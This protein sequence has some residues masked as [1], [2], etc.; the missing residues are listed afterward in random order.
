MHPALIFNTFVKF[1]SKQTSLFFQLM[2]TAGLGSIIMNS[3][4]AQTA[5]RCDDPVFGAAGI[6]IDQRAATAV[7]ARE[8]GVKKATETALLQVLSRVLLSDADRQRFA[9]THQS[10]AFLDFVHII[11]ENNLDKRYIASLDFCFDAHRMRAAL[12]ADGLQWAE[13]ESPPILLLPVWEDPDGASAW[14]KNNHWIAGWRAEVTS[15]SGLVNLQ[16]L[17][18]TLTHERRFRG[19]DLITGDPVKLSAAAKIVSAAQIMVVIA[20]LDYQGSKKV[21]DVE[22]RLFD[23]AGQRITTIISLPK[24]ELNKKDFKQL[25]TARQTVMDRVQESWRSANL[26]NSNAAGYLLATLPVST[27]KQW[28]DR[29]DALRQVAV[30][31]SMTIRTL[32]KGSGTVSLALAG[33]REALQ[34]ALASQGL[35]L[36]DEGDLVSIITKSDL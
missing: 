13:L 21:V 5:N 20:S 27:A 23:K 3:A 29:L 34:N 31:E 2:I 22:A 30:I 10:D 17:P 15:Y 26:I 36:I 18:H 6:A 25:D 24:I 19:D 8:V 35:M 4:M 28:S 11:K 9:S 16:L 33:S 7:E 14:Q 12:Q 1:L 32:D